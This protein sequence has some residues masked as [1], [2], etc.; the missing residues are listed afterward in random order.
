MEK[1]S[2]LEEVTRTVNEDR[3]MLNSIGEG[4]LDGLAMF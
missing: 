1:F 4:K 2:R 3:Q